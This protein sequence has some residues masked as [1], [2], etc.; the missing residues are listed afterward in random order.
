VGADRGTI[1]GFLFGTN[2]VQAYFDHNIMSNMTTA[3]YHNGLPLEGISL[4]LE[5]LHRIKPEYIVAYSAE[6]QVMVE[7]GAPLLFAEGYDL[8]HFSDG[9]YLYKRAVYQ[10]ETYFIFRRSGGNTGKLPPGSEP[11]Y[12]SNK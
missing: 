11:R 8:V 3:Y 12:G 1:F 5:E 7:T 2:A 6:P 4:E 9:Y 10:R